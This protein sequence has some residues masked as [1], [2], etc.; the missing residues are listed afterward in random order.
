MAFQDMLDLSD[1]TVGQ[2]SALYSRKDQDDK[3]LNVDFAVNHWLD[4]KF[5]PEKINLGI[6]AHVGILIVQ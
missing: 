3:T 5:P 2:H 6:A 1:M 4:N